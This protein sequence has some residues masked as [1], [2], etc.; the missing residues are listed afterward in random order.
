MIPATMPA[1]LADVIRRHGGEWLTW[2]QTADE[3]GYLRYDGVEAGIIAE[4]GQARSSLEPF[5]SFRSTAENFWTGSA[6]RAAEACVDALV[7]RMAK[8]LYRELAD[9][10]AMNRPSMCSEVSRRLLALSA[11]EREGS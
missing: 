11:R 5:V 4:L 6:E 9:L 3:E 2:E 7:A 1:A 10:A 8:P